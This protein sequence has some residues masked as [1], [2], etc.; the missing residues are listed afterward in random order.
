M[1]TRLLVVALFISPLLFSQNISFGVVGGTNLTDSFGKAS[2][3]TQIP[4]ATGF[5]VASTGPRTLIIGPEIEVK[6][7][8]GFSF[9]ADALHR[10][11]QTSLRFVSSTPGFPNS[12]VTYQTVTPWEIP[13][14]L[15]YRFAVG[16]IHPFVEAGPSFRPGGSGTGSHAG[17]TAGGGIEFHAGDLRISPTVR[18]TR[19]ERS[20]TSA[21]D[22]PDQ[23]EM[24]VGFDWSPQSEKRVALAHRISYGLLG[25]ASLGRDFDPAVSTIFV[26]HPDTNTLV[27]G[28]SIEVRLVKSLSVEVD[29]LYRPLHGTDVPSTSSPD[30]HVVRF[31]TLTWEFPVLAKYRFDAG[32]VKPFIEAGPSFRTSGNLEIGQP[33]NHGATAGIGVEFGLGRMKIAPTFRY[34][35][36]A[37]DQTSLLDGGNGLRNEAQVLLGIRF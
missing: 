6:L 8:W 13:L 23:V 31:A 10:N 16:G 30:D 25:G 5:E 27:I 35:R 15:K 1:R 17:A 24:L 4:Q 28:P 20:F 36:W 22:R 12:R 7:P 33:S 3:F 34:T 9:E 21:P 11:R 2:F 32:L 18:Y 14:L 37:P 29:G 19:W 26:Q